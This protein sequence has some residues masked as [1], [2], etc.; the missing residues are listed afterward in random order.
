MLD[1]PALE[2]E[3]S[4]AH[5]PDEPGFEP[6]DTFLLQVDVQLDEGESNV[7]LMH[8]KLVRLKPNAGTGLTH[9]NESAQLSQLK[10]NASIDQM[11]V[12]ESGQLAPLNPKTSSEL[13]HVN[14]SG[15]LAELE[16]NAS[17]QGKVPNASLS[18]ARAQ[19][20][21]VIPSAAMARQFV[22][23]VEGVQSKKA[24]GEVKSKKPTAE[25]GHSAARS[26]VTL[27]ILEMVPLAGP[28]GA[29]RFYLGDTV[30]GAAKL[31]V[32]I[33]TCFIGGVIWGILDFVCIVQNCFLK[34]ESID[35]LGMKAQ[36]QPEGIE[37]AQSLAQVAVGMHVLFCCAGMGFCSAFY[38]VVR[39]FWTG[40]PRRSC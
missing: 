27:V 39:V 28:L 13:V 7:G 9:L 34:S 40:V 18:A 1:C 36:F 29:D 19:Q 23:N 33:C 6:D 35:I 21:R 14:G 12:H 8:P 20:A 31:I 16:P 30:G 3:A 11:H 24:I 10:P 22:V 5:K 17:Y 38:R 4:C 15:Q 37:Q 25:K 26:K 2:D 32:C